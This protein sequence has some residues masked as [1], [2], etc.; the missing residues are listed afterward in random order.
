MYSINK[1]VTHNNY[2]MVFCDKKLFSKF[3]KVNEG[4]RL[5]LVRRMVIIKSM[6]Y[7]S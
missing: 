5:C 6:Q 4:G 3:K 1:Y 2:L 7:Q